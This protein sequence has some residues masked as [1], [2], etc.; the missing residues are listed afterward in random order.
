[1]MVPWAEA[2]KSIISCEIR[3]DVSR[4]CKTW[5]WLETIHLLDRVQSTSS[6]VSKRNEI[7]LSGEL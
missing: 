3:E 6:E 2:R 5:D 4:P 7:K 1:M